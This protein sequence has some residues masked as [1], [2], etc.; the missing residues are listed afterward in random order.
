[1]TFTVVAAK[2][3]ISADLNGKSDPYVK[4]LYSVDGFSQEVF[5]TDK[6]KTTLNPNWLEKKDKAS[7][8]HTVTISE[9]SSVVFKVM[10]WDK[11]GKHDP[12]G[13][14]EFD[15]ERI[16][17]ILNDSPGEFVE[18][19]VWFTI[20]NKKMKGEL[21]LIL[22]LRHGAAV[23]TKRTTQHQSL[24]DSRKAT[25]KAT[26]QIRRTGTNVKEKVHSRKLPPEVLENEENQFIESIVTIVSRYTDIDENIKN[27]IMGDLRA[28]LYLFEGKVGV[29]G[30]SLVIDERDAIGREIP[31]ELLDLSTG[32]DSSPR[33]RISADLPRLVSKL[34]VILVEV[35]REF[36]GT[37]GIKNQILAPEH[38]CQKIFQ[39]VC[40]Q[41]VSMINVLGDS[42]L[43]IS[44]AKT[45]GWVKKVLSSILY[46]P[47]TELLDFSKHL[48]RGGRMANHIM[49]Q[50]LSTILQQHQDLTRLC[51]ALLSCF[52]T[53]TST[54][55]MGIVCITSMLQST[56]DLLVKMSQN[57]NTTYSLGQ[58]IKELQL[59]KE[60]IPSKKE[61]ITIVKAAFSDPE[62]VASIINPSD[63]LRPGSIPHMFNRYLTSDN[64]TT[65]LLQREALLEGYFTLCSADYLWAVIEAS[66]ELSSDLGVEAHQVHNRISVF[67]Q[68]LVKRDPHRMSR[69]LMNKINEFV[70]HNRSTLELPSKILS[71]L[72]NTELFLISEEKLKIP[73][74]PLIFDTCGIPYHQT[75]LHFHTFDIADQLTL[76][77]WL[78]YSQI[79]K[80]QLR[81][82]KWDKPV[83][84]AMG[85]NVARM[86]QRLN[87]LAHWVAT[88]LLA[89]EDTE[90]RAIV[91]TH[92]I[93]LAHKLLQRNN[94]GSFMGILT[95]LNMVSTSRLKIT[96]RCVAPHIL[97][98]METLC[99][100]QDP[101]SSFG[102]LRAKMKESG[103]QL[104]PYIGTFLADM[105]LIDEGNPNTVT[106]DQTT[107]VNF[108][109]YGLVSNA[110]KDFQQFQKLA[111]FK[112]LKPKEPLFSFLLVLPSLGTEELYSLSLKREPRVT[113]P[114]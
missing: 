5:R 50:L 18:V 17:S 97:N 33:S 61:M 37:N 96:D 76:I 95:G 15:Y 24:A 40:Q 81:L 71:L 1:M 91:K 105:T 77:D 58:K 88:L 102:T 39:S 25:R 52:N 78:T 27:R 90:E 42:L 114:Q 93:S 69:N 72:N 79:P 44:E 45:Q 67:L 29:E 112:E 3:L 36:N 28:E 87:K 62:P 103:S 46:P 86:I 82:L 110:I 9:N 107:F 11:I 10:D 80:S 4:V 64:Y 12:L 55:F 48:L 21:L 109:K 43:S 34:G 38:L 56:N 113:S 26:K 35:V 83:D 32:Q 54:E 108:P 31:A 7:L 65:V 2:N 8:T 53:A 66:W 23:K 106:V 19:P 47:K 98:Q 49:T 16:K 111:E 22:T 68:K 20:T 73:S 59:K 89:S 14:V 57:V 85:Y 94:Y 75:I 51:C 41:L 6:I 92:F 63:P 74:A 101:T 60:E 13:D 104:L 30:R 84:E 99:K 70:D 100:L